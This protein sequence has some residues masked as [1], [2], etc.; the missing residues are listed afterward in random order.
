MDRDPQVPI[1]MG[2]NPSLLLNGETPRLIDEWQ[3]YPEI[4]N[5]IRHEVDDRKAKGLNYIVALEDS[6]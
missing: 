4:W 2:T 3:V 5:Y 6:R 1:I